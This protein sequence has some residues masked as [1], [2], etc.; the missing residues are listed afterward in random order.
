M[1]VEAGSWLTIMIPRLDPQLAAG[2]AKCIEQKRAQLYDQA[3]VC[4]PCVF[5]LTFMFP[6]VKRY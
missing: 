1:Q 6:Y 3:K 5:H 4:L 2:V